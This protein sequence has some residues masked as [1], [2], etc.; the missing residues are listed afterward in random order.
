MTTSSTSGINRDFDPDIPPIPTQPVHLGSDPGRLISVLPALL[1][2]PPRESLLLLG[3]H[4]P[5]GATAARRQLGPLIRTDLDHHAAADAAETM[6]HNLASE[7]DPE[8]IVLVVSEDRSLARDFATTYVGLFLR[9]GMAINGTFLVDE[10]T[11]GARWEEMTS[12]EMGLVGDVKD[13]AVAD[14]RAVHRSQPMGSR[15]ELD[16]WLDPVAPLSEVLDCQEELPH[17]MQA[18]AATVIGVLKRIQAIDAGEQRIEDA[19]EDTDFLDVVNILCAD[20][21]GHTIMAAATCGSPSAIAR[22][23]LATAVRT[24]SGPMRRRLMFILSLVLAAND[25]GTLA[26]HTLNR[27]LEELCMA[28]VC[29]LDGE[30]ILPQDRGLRMD[31]ET[32]LMAEGA[33]ESHIN[34]HVKVL[35]NLIFSHSFE[36]LN[37]IR[38]DFD[39]AE[40]LTAKG[41]EERRFVSRHRDFMAFGV[42]QGFRESKRSLEFPEDPAMGFLDELPAGIWDNYRTQ[43]DE[44]IDRLDWDFINAVLNVPARQAPW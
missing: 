2:F 35:I 28:G 20:T 10:V 37:A 12:G 32:A 17:S 1:G 7:Q 40:E 36:V 39:I 19:L 38:E 33:A 24:N 9:E 15:E 41:P 4:R 21:Y 6:L 44:V 27:V 18:S 3:L 13:N 26:F 42:A 31:L 23:I 22:E 25:E 16:A 8:V 43:F 14:L 11:T 30:D 29:E 34:G 5:L